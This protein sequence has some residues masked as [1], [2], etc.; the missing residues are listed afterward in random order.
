MNTS[1]SFD[2]YEWQK[3]PI[4]PTKTPGQVFYDEASKDTL[5]REWNQLSKAEQERYERACTLVLTVFGA[6]H[7]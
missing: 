5:F 1:L 3:K 6:K 7:A 2:R 4:I